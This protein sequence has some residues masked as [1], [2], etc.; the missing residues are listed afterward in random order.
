MWRPASLAAP[1]PGT[2]LGGFGYLRFHGTSGRYAGRYDDGTL[3]RWAAWIA[4][5]LVHGRDVYAYFNNDIDGHAHGGIR[6]IGE[7][8][9]NVRDHE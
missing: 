7:R 9:R 5:E 4:G 1:S 6:R 8:S 2:L 3:D